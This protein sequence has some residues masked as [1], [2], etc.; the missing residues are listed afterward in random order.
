MW[1]YPYTPA[2]RTVALSLATLRSETKGVLAKAGAV[3]KLIGAFLL[4]WRV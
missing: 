4:R 2:L 1:W 3:V